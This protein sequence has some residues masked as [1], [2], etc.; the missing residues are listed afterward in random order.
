MGPLHHMGFTD[1]RFTSAMRRLPEGTD[2]RHSGRID[3]VVDVLTCRAKRLDLGRARAG[4]SQKGRRPTRSW[5][6]KSSI[7]SD[8]ALELSS[9]GWVVRFAWE[10]SRGLIWP[11]RL[12]FTVTTRT[13]SLKRSAD[14]TLTPN[15]PPDVEAVRRTT[16]GCRSERVRDP[17]GVMVEQAR[18][19][20]R[21]ARS[22]IRTGGPSGHSGASCSTRQAPAS[23]ERPR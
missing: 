19:T 5:R 16:E 8:F 22:P 1:Q 11:L 7:A 15:R 12:S 6:A 13:S 17:L 10:N 2:L 9:S 23:G 18:S 20:P 4:R 21:P 3:Q 14:D